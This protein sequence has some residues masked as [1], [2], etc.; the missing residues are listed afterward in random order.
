MWG[1]GVYEAVSKNKKGTEWG[2][3]LSLSSKISNTHEEV[4][5]GQYMKTTLKTRDLCVRLPHSGVA[6]E[7]AAQTWGQPFW[8]ALRLNDATVLT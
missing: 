7:R 4:A 8:L 6:G 1:K 3:G 5:P 2:W